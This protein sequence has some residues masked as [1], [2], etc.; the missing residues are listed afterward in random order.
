[1]SLPI[2]NAVT[3]PIVNFAILNYIEKTAHSVSKTEKKIKCYKL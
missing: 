2:G 1:M 3:V